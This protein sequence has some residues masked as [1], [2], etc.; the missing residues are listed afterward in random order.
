MGAILVQHHDNSPFEALSEVWQKQKRWEQKHKAAAPKRRDCNSG[1]GGGFM[2]A[3]AYIQ[4]SSDID[5]LS[6]S[7]RRDAEELNDTAS[8]CSEASFCSDV[9]SQFECEIDGERRLIVSS[10]ASSCSSASCFS[11]R[12]R[13]SALPPI[14]EYCATPTSPGG[15]CY[16]DTLEDY[17]AG[18][19]PLL[20]TRGELLKFFVRMPADVLAGP[21]MV[22]AAG[23]HLAHREL[24]EAL[25]SSIACLAKVSKMPQSQVLCLGE[26]F[27]YGRE[28]Y[29]LSGEVYTRLLILA[30]PL[31]GLGD[32]HAGSPLPIKMKLTDV[33]SRAPF[34]AELLAMRREL[35]AG[36]Q[37]QLSGQSALKRRRRTLKHVADALK[38]LKRSGGSKR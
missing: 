7:F 14:S 37:Q 33:T 38:A 20:V 2:R 12:S 31:E 29:S 26:G 21:Q 13:R 19:R 24:L 36:M 25:C 6:E 15:S 3:R 30:R 22:G 9:S 18:L 4:T 16:E 10:S 23:A 35:Q 1:R 8:V 28:S 34:L 11:T 5:G 32:V 27:E 17:A